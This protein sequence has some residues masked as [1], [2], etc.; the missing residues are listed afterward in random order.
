[1]TYSEVKA[2]LKKQQNVITQYKLIETMN[3][4]LILSADHLVYARKRFFDK[5][6]PM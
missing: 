6:Y 5:F 4:T 3:K 1:M 2:F